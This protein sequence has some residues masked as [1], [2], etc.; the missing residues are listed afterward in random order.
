M[1]LGTSAWGQKVERL[2]TGPRKKIY[3]IFRHLDTIDERDRQ[4]DGHRTT[5]WPCL[6][7]ASR[8][9]NH[10]LQNVTKNWDKSRL[11]GLKLWM[12]FKLPDLSF[13]TGT[14]T[15]EPEPSGTNPCGTNRPNSSFR[16]TT[17]LGRAYSKCSA[18]R[19]SGPQALTINI[20]DTYP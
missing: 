7:I 11:I 4:T 19:P 5:A 9:K 3:D 13:I 14:I 17:R 6:R 20:C 1:K 15:S 8:G 10:M 18:D 12:S 2:A 16:C